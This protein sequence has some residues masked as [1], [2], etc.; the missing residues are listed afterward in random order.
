MLNPSTADALVDDATVRKC[1]AFAKRWGRAGIKVVNLFAYRATDPDEMVAAPDPVGPRN[2]RLL[3]A[4]AA[5]SAR[6]GEEIV[7]GWGAVAGRPKV[8]ERAKAMIAVLNGNRGRLLALEVTL[9]GHPGHPL[10]L[11]LKRRPFAFAAE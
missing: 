1:I 10:Y 3:S 2:I 11:P 8:A 4:I 5:H 7:C 9:G 6:T